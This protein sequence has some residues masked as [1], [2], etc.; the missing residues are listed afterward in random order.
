MISQGKILGKLK[1]QLTP[2]IKFQWLNSEFS[3]MKQFPRSVQVGFS[4]PVDPTCTLH[5]IDDLPHKPELSS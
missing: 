3:C 5:W 1:T 4:L 2:I